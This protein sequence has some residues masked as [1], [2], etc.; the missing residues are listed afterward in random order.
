ME[1]KKRDPWKGRGTLCRVEAEEREGGRSKKE[2]VWADLA[3]RGRRPKVD[4]AEDERELGQ[5]ESHF[6]SDSKRE[7]EEKSWPGLAQVKLFRDG[8]VIQTTEIQ[9][10]ATWREETINE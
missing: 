9:N 8:C 5:S 3:G 4:R 1:E 2:S 10:V 7:R 6:R